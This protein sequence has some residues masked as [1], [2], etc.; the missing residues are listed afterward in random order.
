MIDGHYG[1]SATSYP[2]DASSDKTPTPPLS[3]HAQSATDVSIDTDSYQDVRVQNSDSE[4]RFSSEEET[5]RDPSSSSYSLTVETPSD[6]RIYRKEKPVPT[7][8]NFYGNDE[9]SYRLYQNEG[10]SE[11]QV[12]YKE[13]ERSQGASRAVHISSYGRYSDSSSRYY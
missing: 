11:E 5:Q 4:C 10:P 1:S 7:R 9:P 6:Y 12:R 8:Y 2:R 3:H 13:R